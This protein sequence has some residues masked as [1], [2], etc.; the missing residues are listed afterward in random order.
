M[1]DEIS[2]IEAA[3]KA[4]ADLAAKRKELKTNIGKTFTNGEEE[5]KVSSFVPDKMLGSKSGDA[6]L[7]NLGNPNAHHFIFCE[8][9]LTN[10]K[11]K[12]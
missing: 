9:F 10:Y 3:K 4:E 6:F 8:E 2:P 12:E 5:A 11:A 7:V 1:P